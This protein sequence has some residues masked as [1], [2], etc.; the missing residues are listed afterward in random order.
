M[1]ILLL[2]AG[3]GVNRRADRRGSTVHVAAS[4]LGEFRKLRCD[5]NLDF[6]ALEITA[7]RTPLYQ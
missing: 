5:Q 2:F 4:V 1:T 3:V 6:Y 7:D